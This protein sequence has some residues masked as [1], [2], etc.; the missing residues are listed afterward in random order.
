[1]LTHRLDP[2][3]GT[4]M[5]HRYDTPTT[6]RRHAEYAPATNDHFTSSS[7]HNDDTPMTHRRDP[8]PRRRHT[9]DTPL[10]RRPHTGHTRSHPPADGTTMRRKTGR[11]TSRHTLDHEQSLADWSPWPLGRRAGMQRSGGTPLC[12]RR[13]SRQPRTRAGLD[14]KLARGRRTR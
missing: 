3:D 10:T 1:M 5:T 14:D 12:P 7:A 6:R 2:H 4:P 11:R 9:D 13:G 8:A